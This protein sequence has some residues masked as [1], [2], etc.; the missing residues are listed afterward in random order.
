[1]DFCG[2][3]YSFGTGFDM[4]PRADI[5]ERL[6]SYSCGI[7]VQARTGC[8][9]V[10]IEVAMMAKFYEVNVRERD[11]LYMGHEQQNEIMTGELEQFGGACIAVDYK[12]R[13]RFNDE[14]R[15]T[16][17]LLRWS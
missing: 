16:A 17:F 6:V 2:C 15:F 13:L 10:F 3:A 11:S 9:N 4:V 14:S 12:T 7:L 5:L 8:H 1:V